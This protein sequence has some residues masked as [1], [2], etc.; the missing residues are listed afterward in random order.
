M[1][2]LPSR[3]HYHFRIRMMPFPAPA[4][5]SALPGP[6][7]G[8]RAPATSS[9]RTQFCIVSIRRP[10]RHRSRARSGRY[11][12]SWEG[13]EVPHTPAH[14]ARSVPGRLGRRYSL[15]RVSS[16]PE[17]RPPSTGAGNTSSTP[18]A[19]LDG[20]DTAYREV[21]ALL[22]PIIDQALASP[23]EVRNIVGMDDFQTEIPL[24]RIVDHRGAKA[25]TED[26]G[27]SWTGYIP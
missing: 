25:G 9:H 15:L 24:S 21:L 14:A 19:F 1:T 20:I 23:P 10:Q 7:S 2:V 27:E 22:A 3:E 5:R 16:S 13:G 26:C 6:S 18:F 4:D 12:L 17:G 8:R 11:H